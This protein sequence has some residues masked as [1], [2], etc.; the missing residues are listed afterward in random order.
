MSRQPCRHFTAEFKEQAVAVERLAAGAGG[1]GLALN[2][3]AVI[4]EPH[5]QGQIE[6][7]IVDEA[8]RL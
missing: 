8:E 7:L 4:P 2:P 3:G 1:R 5:A 6:I